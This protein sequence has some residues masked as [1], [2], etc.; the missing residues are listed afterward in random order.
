MSDFNYNPSYSTQINHKP[1]TKKAVF[2]D[3]YVQRAADGINNAPEMWSLVFN[4]KTNSDADAIETFLKGKGGHAA[5]TWTPNGRSEIKVICESWNRSY[6][7]SGLSNITMTF[8][9]VFDG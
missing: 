2:G 1:R 3:G 5:F 9:Q 8:E 7:G 6:A 4:A